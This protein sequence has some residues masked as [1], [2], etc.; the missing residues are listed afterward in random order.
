MYYIVKLIICY[1]YCIKENPTSAGKKEASVKCRCYGVGGLAANASAG[2]L[3]S[4][5][6]VIILYKSEE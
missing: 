4:I 5:N 3:V 2:M 6:R 1:L